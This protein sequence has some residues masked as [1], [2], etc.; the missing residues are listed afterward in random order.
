MF[1]KTFSL[2]AQSSLYHFPVPCRPKFDVA[3]LVPDDN[4]TE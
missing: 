3:K 2:G 1:T 4:I